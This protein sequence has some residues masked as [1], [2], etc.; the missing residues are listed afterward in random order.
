MSQPS[1]K[2]KICVQLGIGHPPAN[3]SRQRQKLPFETNSGRATVFIARIS[4][5]IYADEI[6]GAEK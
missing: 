3:L 6:C 5:S 4:E 2:I 1:G